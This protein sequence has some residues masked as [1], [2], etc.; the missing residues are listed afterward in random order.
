[1]A[2]TPPPPPPGAVLEAYINFSRDAR[3]PF[4]QLTC[5]VWEYYQPRSPS[6]MTLVDM[7]GNSISQ[8]IADSHAAGIPCTCQVYVPWSNPAYNIIFADPSVGNALIDNVIDKIR[9]HGFDGVDMDLECDNRPGE[10]PEYTGQAQVDA[11]YA[12]LYQRMQLA[13]PTVHK[14]I[15][16]A[17]NFEGAPPMS[18]AAA[19]YFDWIS[20]MVYDIPVPYG[21]LADVQSAMRKY[22]DAGFPKNKLVAGIQFVAYPY[23]IT[24]YRN[25]ILPANPPPSANSWAG[26]QYSG[27]ELNAAKTRWVL[28]NGYRGVFIYTIEADDFGISYARNL[29]LFWAIRD[30]FGA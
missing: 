18:A 23:S 14:L 27:A 19:Q 5:N 3:V 15:T 1:M 8:V 7:N 12:N 2:G 28:D 17:E 26:Y 6:D 9:T 16:C 24:A 4:P 29:S 25:I 22:S 20:V 30:Q 13:F 11:F 10:P 21:T